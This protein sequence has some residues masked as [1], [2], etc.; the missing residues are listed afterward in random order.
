M[1]RSRGDEFREILTVR[2]ERKQWIVIEKVIESGLNP[3]VLPP[4]DDYL[5]QYEF[6]FFLKLRKSNNENE[7][8]G[9]FEFCAPHFHDRF[10]GEG[11][12]GVGRCF[13]PPC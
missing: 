6:L 9:N 7:F 4:F 12:P 11:L 8:T 5:S 1:Q 3:L 2:K 13:L 10:E